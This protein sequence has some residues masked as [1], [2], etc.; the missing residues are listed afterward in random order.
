[1]QAYKALNF[2]RNRLLKLQIP[3][4]WS[5][6]VADSIS[7]LSLASLTL[8]P[9]FPLFLELFPFRGPRY[10][11][12]SRRMNSARFILTSEG[13]RREDKWNALAER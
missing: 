7:Q 3:L 1:M 6:F 9:G 12:P 10:E 11:W 5:L 4:P 13:N 2:D 8:S